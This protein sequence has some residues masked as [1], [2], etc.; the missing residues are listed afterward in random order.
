MTLGG[1]ALVMGRLVDD[2][3]VDI[4]NTFRHLA[5]GKSP[6]QAALDSAMEIAMPVLVATITTVAVFF[7]VVFLFGMGKYLFTPLAL[8][9]AFAMFASYLLSRTLSPAY[10]AYFLK[11]EVHDGKRFWLFR[12]CDAGFE[13]VKTGYTALLRQA[14][15]PRWPVVLGSLVLLA[16][17]FALYP[18]LG[19]ELFPVTD[20]GQIVIN[21]RAPSGTRIENTESLTKSIEAVIKAEIPDA[22]RQMIV[23]DIGVL[24]DWPAG[25]TANSG[26]MDATMLV[27]LTDAEQ[28]RTS[29]QEYANRLRT[30]LNEKFPGVQ[31][32]FNTGGMIAAALNFGLPAPINIQVEGRD[33]KEQFRIAGQIKSMI[34]RDVPG[35]VDVRIQETIDYPTIELEPDRVKMAYSGLSQ[36]D[37]VKNLMSV[38][39][40]STTFDPAFWLDYKSGNHYF[41]GVTYEEQNIKDFNTLKNVPLTG[42]QSQGVVQLQN[43]VGEPKLTTSAVEVSHLALTRVVN[44]YANVQGRDV[45]AVAADIERVLSEWGRREEAGGNVASWSV[46]DPANPEKALPGYAVQ[47][48]GE[49]SNMA[50]SFQS[51]GF[52]LILAVVLIYLIM[53][54][55]FR[56][57]LDPFIILFAVPLGLIGVLLI[58]FLTGTTLNVQSFMG[59]IFMVGIAVSNSILL[60]EFANRLRRE[61]GLEVY[62][63]AVQAGSV[64]L[65]PILMTSLAA[66]VGLIPLALH[67]GEATMPLARAVIGGL[68][69]STALTIFVVPCLYVMFKGRSARP[70]TTDGGSR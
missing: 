20:A 43:V 8:S 48:R 29:S 58:L 5:M 34:A 46:R 65:R 7:P 2:P 52:G 57:F 30:T 9:V 28:R 19:R 64:R 39:N 67:E 23:T 37:T 13:W 54:A 32:S 56:S 53:V 24:Y 11:A 1:L 42:K 49:V 27:Q 63:A 38:L 70:A 68:S 47:M 41:V 6:R 35:A 55:Q 31:F 50:Q 59:V 51:L 21:V 66:I 16:A 15:K 17:S 18:L 33:M 26:P 25:Y 62:E 36:E 10:C 40:S 3:I 69:V 22:D 44:I 45:G 14:M 4:E 61:Q 60:V 12:V